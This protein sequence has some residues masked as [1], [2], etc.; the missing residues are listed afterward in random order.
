MR[1]GGVGI[2]RMMLRA[3]TLLPEPDSPTMPSVSPRLMWKS[4]PSTARTTPSSVKKYVF[5]PLT[6]SSRSAMTPPLARYHNWLAS[7][8][9][10]WITDSPR[11]WL[12]L[13][14]PGSQ[15]RLAARVAEPPR[16]PLGSHY[17]R[18]VISPNASSAR[19]TSSASMSLWVT[20]RIEIGPIE[21]IRSEEHTSELQSLA[22]LVCRLLLEKKKN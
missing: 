1:P 10:A 9:G 6:S 7:D 14:L 17:H 4:I 11:L 8:G 3:V 5:S 22:Y 2:S 19:S 18:L 15:T 21:W 16:P 12:R 20:Q 13:A